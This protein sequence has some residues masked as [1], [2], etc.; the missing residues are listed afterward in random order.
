MNDICL[1]SSAPDEARVAVS[2]FPWHY[3]YCLFCKHCPVKNDKFSVYFAIIV[4]CKAMC[5]VVTYCCKLVSTQIVRLIIRE[6][7]VTAVSINYVVFANLSES[8]S[9]A[10]CWLKKFIV[11]YG[12][13]ECLYIINMRE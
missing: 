11:L 2:W 1:K 7:K 5:T 13:N 8:G 3:Y 4:E 9:P 6:L 10:V 12:L